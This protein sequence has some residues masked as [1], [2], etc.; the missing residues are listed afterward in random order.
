VNEASRHIHHRHSKCLASIDASELQSLKP[1]T[2]TLALNQADLKA[3]ARRRL[4][5]AILD[6]IEGGSYDEV[7]LKA[8]RA[9][10]AAL[11]LRQRV[12]TDIASRKLDTTIVGQHASIPVALGPIGFAGLMYP[13][14]EIYIARAAQSFG[15]PFCLSTLSTCSIEEL[16]EAAEDPFFFQ[17]Y[18]FKDR[19]VNRALLQ[20]AE[21]AGCPALV[22]TLDAAVHGRRD[23]DLHNGLTVPLKVRTRLALEM[24]LKPRW[25][26]GW[27]SSKRTIGSLAM[28]VPGRAELEEVSAWAEHNYKGPIVTSDVEWVRNHWQRKLILKGILDPNDA[29]LAAKLGADAIVVSNHGGRQ[30]DGAQTPVKAFPAIKDAVG[31]SV[32]LA[33]DS[34]VRSGLDVLKALGLGAKACFLGRAYLYGLAAYGEAGV[35]AALQLV[36]A[37]LDAG[38]ALTGVN[39]VTKVGPDLLVTSKSR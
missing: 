13:R 14:G 39:D 8:N 4:P 33:F 10:L 5:R 2:E 25:A 21:E 36:A 18:L 11:V 30:L 26:L 22:L 7:T 28:F 38:M 34:G 12:L 15:V 24:L 16:V 6:Y 23:R 37:E 35:I 31:E 17:L 29:R 1:K 19:A 3:A 9:D 20:R 27:F 32:D